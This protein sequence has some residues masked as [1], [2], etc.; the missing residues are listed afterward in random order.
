MTPQPYVRA[1]RVVVC[2]W[3]RSRRIQGVSAV[4]APCTSFCELLCRIFYCTF[5]VDLIIT[6]CHVVYKGVPRTFLVTC[7]ISITSSI[8][9]IEC[10]LSMRCCA[11]LDSPFPY[12][13]SWKCSWNVTWKDPPVCPVYFLLQSWHVNW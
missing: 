8:G 3:A 13:K 6:S 1:A 9:A 2:D 7:K 4:N 11:N 10:L 5:I 12:L